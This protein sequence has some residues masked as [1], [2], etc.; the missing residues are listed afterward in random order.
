MEL[1]AGNDEVAR[2]LHKRSEWHDQR[3]KGIGGSDTNVIM[4]GDWHDLWL[5]KTGRT[6][7]VDLSNNLAVAMGTW[8]EALN[9][10]W[11]TG[12]TGISILH[13]AEPFVHP[14]FTF[15]RANLDGFIN[16]PE[17][18][19]F[20]AKHT[21]AWEKDENAVSRFY[22]QCQHN[23]EVAAAD[24]CFLSVFFGSDKWKYFDL[25]R[26]QTSV[27]DLLLKEELFWGYVERD[28]PPPR[29]AAEAPIKI[30]FDKMGEIDLSS[31]NAWCE[32][33][34]DWLKN[35]AAAKKFDIAVEELKELVPADAKLAK[36]AG[37]T[38][39]R[40]KAGALTIKEAR[41]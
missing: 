10:Y 38:I 21:N 23:M 19:V 27:N 39:S 17:D 9:R 40:S 35:K 15:M 5:E 24:T 7:P 28:E 12:Q 34:G 13:G 14:K 20:E 41:S 26:D 8:T 29:M 18:A 31:S 22:W 3:R 2:L 36:G 1:S 30:E 6:P 25:K 4:S 16:D 33:A 32:F 11:F 37:I